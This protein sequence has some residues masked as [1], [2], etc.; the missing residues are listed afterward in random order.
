MLKLN[1]HI[2]RTPAAKRKPL[3]RSSSP[4]TRRCSRVQ[5]RPLAAAASAP[6]SVLR[7][8]QL[9]FTRR[10]QLRTSSCRPGTPAALLWL[11]LAAVDALVHVAGCPS[12]RRRCRG[13][14][15]T[16]RARPPRQSVAAAVALCTSGCWRLLAMAA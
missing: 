1:P 2:Q 4:S 6:H 11:P 7:P 12:N 15:P 8:Q 16:A 9:P 3:S 14:T 10:A 13:C 5:P